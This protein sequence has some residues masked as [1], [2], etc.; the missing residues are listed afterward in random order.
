MKTT[1]V[2]QGRK[3]KTFGQQE[4]Y[5]HV[6]KSIFNERLKCKDGVWLRNVDITVEP[7]KLAR[8]VRR[9]IEKRMCQTY[10]KQHKGTFHEHSNRSR[11][12]MKRAVS[13]ELYIIGQIENVDNRSRGDSTHWKRLYDPITGQIVFRKKMGYQTIE[14]AK[15]SAIRLVE[16]Y[17]MC[18]KGVS[19]Y[20][21]PHCN[22]Y[23][24]G[25]ESSMTT[26]PILTIS[27][28]APV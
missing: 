7:P 15:S 10:H 3:Q 14:E 5:C 1:N 11:H 4:R 19:V 23:H 22:Q 13:Y 6:T 18:N 25:H 27:P 16:D 26:N 9:I 20:M 2:E 8:K 28:L 24:I 21:C 12:N 17:P